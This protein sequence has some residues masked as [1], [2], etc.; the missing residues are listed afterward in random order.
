[1]PDIDP[2]GFVSDA[3]RELFRQGKP[4]VTYEEVEECGL[5]HIQDVDL[6]PEYAHRLASNDYAGDYDYVDDGCGKFVKQT[7]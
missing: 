6:A 2:G 3:L 1:M 5:A 4:I 7:A